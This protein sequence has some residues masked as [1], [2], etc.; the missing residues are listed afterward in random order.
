MAAEKKKTLYIEVLRIIAILFV[1]FNHTKQNGY[2]HFTLYEPGTLK[3]WFYMFFSVIAGIG[4]PVFY[5]VSGAVLIGKDEPVSYIWKKRIPKYVL[6]LVVFS[7]IL[8]LWKALPDDSF[9]FL[10]FLKHIYSDGVI[11]PYW[12]LYSYI[13]FLM[14]LPVIRRAVTNMTDQ[15]FH[16]LFGLW[17]VFN[18]LIF[19]LQYRLSNGTLSMNELLF[20]SLLTN[21]LFFYPA[22]GYYLMVRLKKV[23]DKMCLTALVLAVITIAV[24]MYITG[25]RINLTGDINESTVNY[26]YECNRPFQVVFI[27]LAVR[28]MFESKMISSLPDMILRNLGGCVFGIYLIEEIGR[29]ILLPVYIRMCSGIN[30]FAAVWIYVLLVFILCWF[31]A[32]S[33]KYIFGF[34]MRVLVK[35]DKPGS[36]QTD[37]S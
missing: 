18:S 25:F 15:E 14:I 3:F 26:F 1:I 11:V 31:L 33:V 36:Q 37:H 24:T 27:I 34:I 29:D 12:F 22:L 4:V 5:S 9:S 7:L 17:I 32:A 30:S 16:Y 19:I 23:S 10:S 21:M 35:R 6:V 2:V 8:S 28:K 20:P 13:G